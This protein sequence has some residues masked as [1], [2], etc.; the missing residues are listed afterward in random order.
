MRNKLIEFL[1]LGLQ[2]LANSFLLKKDLN[3][4]E[5]KYKLIVCFNKEN[6]LV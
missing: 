6:K 4:K 1:D 3:K 5:K 2:P